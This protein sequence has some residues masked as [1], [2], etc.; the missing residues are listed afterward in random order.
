[1]IIRKRTRKKRQTPPKKRPAAVAIGVTGLLLLVCVSAFGVYRLITSRLT[2]KTPLF[3]THVSLGMEAKVKDIDRRIC[4]ALLD[5]EVP[6]EDVIFNAV[7]PRQDGEERWTYS[8]LKIRI[9]EGFPLEHVK[10]IFSKQLSAVIPRTSIRF[11]S[12]PR[13]ETILELSVNRRPTHRIAFIMFTHK[14][15]PIA[16]PSSPP[17]VAIIIDDL[18]YDHIMA[19]KFLELDGILSFSVL[20]HSPFQHRIATAIYR[21]GR[22]V[23]LHLPMEPVEYPDADPGRGALLSSMGPDVLLDQLE[24]DLDA[25]PYVVGVNNHMGSRLTQDSSK[26]RQIFTLLKRRNL[27]FI[28]SLTSPKS[29]CSQAA[30]LLQLKFAQRDVFLDHF[31]DPNAI[32]LQI[33]RLI[34]LANTHGQAIGIAHPYPVTWETLKQELP[35][36]RRQVKLVPVSQLVG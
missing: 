6:A 7:E 15:P 34:T 2:H 21:S 19:S 32:R 33:K 11:K 1:M 18:G 27:F 22:D 5:L 8:D 29:R 25:V 24:R 4:D 12:G 17:L 14:K 23:L 20:P 30:E 31:Q 26:M 28:D 3:E 36:I 16:P 13:H 9:H 10:A 35:K